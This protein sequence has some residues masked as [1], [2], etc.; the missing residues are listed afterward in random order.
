MK[1][2][3]WELN[4]ADVKVFEM[5]FLLVDEKECDSVV[6][7]VDLSDKMLILLELEWLQILQQP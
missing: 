7:T 2:D 5:V 4:S 1:G 3:C 6:A